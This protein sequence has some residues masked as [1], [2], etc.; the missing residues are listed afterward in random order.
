M[1]SED[2]WV[3]KRVRVSEDHRKASLRKREGTIVKRWGNPGHAALDV[4]LDDGALRLFWFHELEQA[5][6]DD[7]GARS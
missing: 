3:G 7:G 5:E 2:A 4:L 6:E 1:R